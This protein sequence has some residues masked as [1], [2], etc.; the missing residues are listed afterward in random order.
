N[1]RGETA[2]TFAAAAG[3]A[4]VIRVLT[5]KGADVM[6]T[7]KVVDLAPLAKEEQERFAAKRRLTGPAGRGGRGAAPGPPQPPQI[8]G[9]NRQYNYTELVGFWGALAPLHLAARQGET[10]SV[11]ALMDAGADVNQ[12]GT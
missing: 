12:R 10:D 7:T 2:L 4:D 9:V 1:A 11:K 8:A 3:R 6:V 5:A